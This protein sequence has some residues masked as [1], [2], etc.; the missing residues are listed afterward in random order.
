M[1]L[2][3]WLIVLVVLGSIEAA[4]MLFLRQAMVQA[5]YEGVKVAH[6]KRI[7]AQS[8]PP[9]TRLRRGYD[10]PGCAAPESQPQL[11]PSP[12]VAGRHG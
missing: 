10:L 2:L 5:A 4:S 12:S 6:P 3:D 11:A 9:L 1:A 7:I 8:R